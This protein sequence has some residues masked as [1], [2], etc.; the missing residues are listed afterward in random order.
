MNMK[1][2]VLYIV[3]I[4]SVLS[5]NDPNNSLFEDITER[6]GFALFKESI[7]TVH[8]ISGN[9]DTVINAEIID[10]NNNAISYT[11]AIQRGDGLTN[12]LATVTSFPGSILITRQMVV[13]ALGL[14]DASEL[15]LNVN[16]IGT[17][18][19]PNGTFSGEAID[20]ETITN[21][22]DGGNTQVDA[23]LIPKQA[24][25]FAVIMFQQ[26]PQDEVVVT[27]IRSS[28]DDVEEVAFNPALVPPGDPVGEMDLGSSDLELGE[29][30]SD[31]G[32]Q[33]I[34]LRFTLIGI[35]SG[36]TITSANIQ[37]T[38]DRE[39]SNPV[40]YTLYAENIGNS[41]T[42]TSANSNVTNR[43][44]STSSVVWSIPE[45]ERDD[46]GPA[47]QTPDISSLIQE[48][49]D[50]DDWVPANSI[51]IIMLATGSSLQATS[52]SG[53]REAETFD[54]DAAPEILIA[55]TNSND[56]RS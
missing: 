26:F 39:G 17:I 46:K 4:L 40:E 12:P 48:V 51:S 3:L 43:P 45:W 23:F 28:S 32:I 27:P 9:N 18:T 49:I 7:N 55:Y 52:T 15:P 10:P 16:F 41:E 35:P 14:A 54:G 11:L 44:L 25:R 50:R 1:N 5:C 36:S 37:F 6:G 38:A 30:S 34:G 56:I 33:H 2:I 31:D 8:D 13:D 20:F 21:S 47:Q 53:G 19:T 42:F 24:L 29:T 22:V